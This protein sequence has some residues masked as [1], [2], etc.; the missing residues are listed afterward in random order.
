[1]GATWWGCL[2]VDLRGHMGR[3]QE[4]EYKADSDPRLVSLRVTTCP[5][6]RKR[7]ARKMGCFPREHKEKAVGRRHGRA[8]PSSLSL[9]C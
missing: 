7:E 8:Q 5:Q 2:F 4:Q 3:G 1:M 9:S 6:S